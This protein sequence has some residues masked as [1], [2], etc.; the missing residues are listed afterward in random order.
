MCNVIIYLKGEIYFIMDDA[1]KVTAGERILKLR[2]EKHYTREQLAYMAKI[3]A[4]FLYE[5]ENNKKGFSAVT[6]L[7]LSRALEVSMDYI[8][9]GENVGRAENEIVATLERFKPDALESIKRLLKIAYEL[10]NGNK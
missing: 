8:M 5:I 6:L 3:S 7:N 9:I 4:K 1:K 2:T 10:T